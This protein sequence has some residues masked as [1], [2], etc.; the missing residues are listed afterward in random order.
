MPNTVVPHL[1]LLLYFFAL[2]SPLLPVVMS[3]SWCVNNL[4]SSIAI[5]YINCFT[6]SNQMHLRSY[7]APYYDR[8]EIKGKYENIFTQI[9]IRDEFLCYFVKIF[10]LIYLMNCKKIFGMNRIVPI[11]SVK[12]DTHK[13][14]LVK[15]C[16]N[17]L[18]TFSEPAILVAKTNTSKASS[19]CSLVIYENYTLSIPTSNSQMTC[20]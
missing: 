18:Q 1:F 12:K 17:I 20:I 7:K 2:S 10:H 19:T 5:F 6:Y 13:I 11:S 4:T 9:R 15:Y 8:T 14:W 16:F 3:M